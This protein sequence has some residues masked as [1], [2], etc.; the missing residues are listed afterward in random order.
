MSPPEFSIICRT[1][2]GPVTTVYWFFPRLR[3]GSTIED[4]SSQI[5]VNTSHSVYENILVIR[6]REDGDYQC[7]VR[8]NNFTIK[9]NSISK[10]MFVSGI[11][12]IGRAMSA[13]GFSLAIP[14][15]SCW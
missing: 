8:N 2:G 13:A 7:R 12:V 11:Y 5:V 1:H 3:D 14:E 10:A 4:S 9:E 15:C 6:G